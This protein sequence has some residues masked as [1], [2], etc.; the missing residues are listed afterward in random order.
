MSWK[1]H[2]EQCGDILSLP[3]GHPYHAHMCVCLC[4]HM[5]TCLCV[6]VLRKTTKSWLTFGIQM[7]RTYHLAPVHIPLSLYFNQTEK[8][9][10]PKQTPSI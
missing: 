4:V 2:L 7:G 8:I 10:I 1:I 3:L 9:V 6:Y 5:C